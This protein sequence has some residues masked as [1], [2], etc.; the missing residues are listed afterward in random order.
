MNSPFGKLRINMKKILA[1]FYLVY[2]RI[3]AKIQLRKFNP[4]IIGVGGASGKSSA[5]HLISLILNDKYKV[6]QGKGKNSET[7]IP[8]N[9]LNIN[10]DC[11]C[12]FGLLLFLEAGVY[13]TCFHQ[14]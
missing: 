2:L 12:Q 5:V 9:I 3:F 8:L 10:M 1:R 13:H 11:L 4:L 7:G 14:Y 6:K